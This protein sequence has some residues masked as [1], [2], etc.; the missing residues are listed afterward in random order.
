MIERL[1]NLA[2]PDAIVKE[3]FHNNTEILNE[4]SDQFSKELL[5]FAELFSKAY[6]NHLE[7]DRL[8]KDTE[9]L[10]IAYVSGLTYLLLD[11]LLTSVKLF[12]LG[13]QIPSGNLMRQVLESVALAILCSLKDKITISIKKKKTKE[14]HFYT[15]FFNQESEAK[16][17]LALKYLEANSDK[18]GINKNAIETL[19]VLRS[20][21]HNFSHPGELSLATL[22]SFEKRGKLYI[23]GSFDE[24]KI[25]QYKKELIQRINFCKVLPNIIQGLINNVKQLL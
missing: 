3:L 2:R 19:K 25:V 22:I 14:I 5:E 13:Y 11:N 23:C 16:S 10:Q 24:G 9:N 4:F 7:L 18:I 20:F 15:S 1:I 12:I 21:Y 6:R 17:S 8:I